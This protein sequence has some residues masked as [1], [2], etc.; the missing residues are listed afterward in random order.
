MQ[1]EEMHYPE[2]VHKGFFVRCP[3][4]FPTAYS[5]IHPMVDEN[6]RD[7]LEVLGSN[8]KERL[9]EFISPEILPEVYGGTAKEVQNVCWGGRIPKEMYK[10]NDSTLL[11][12][13]IKPGKKFS[14]E[15][16][17]ERTGME[18]SWEFVTENHDVGFVV[19]YHALG[20]T[21]HEKEEGEKKKEEGEGEEVIPSERV[22]AHHGNI[23]GSYTCEKIGRYVLEWDNSFSWTRGKNLLYKYELA[24][25]S[26]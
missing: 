24:E 1:I 7:K 3:R 23:E 11:R 5:L 16:M 2:V 20:D 22:A 6:T 12:H 14:I 4:I 10:E 8:W 17:V 13:H 25:S 19:Y 21:L 26:K 15:V 9:A 18:L